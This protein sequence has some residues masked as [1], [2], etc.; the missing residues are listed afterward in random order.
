MDVKTALSNYESA[1]DALVVADANVDVAK[2][3]ETDAKAKLDAAS[4]ATAS[5]MEADVMS[6]ASYNQT[7]EDL[8]AALISTKR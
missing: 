3:K 4:A 2:V 5:A 7:V 1:A 8:V 6:V